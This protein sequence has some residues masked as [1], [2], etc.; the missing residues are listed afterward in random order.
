MTTQITHNITQHDDYKNSTRTCVCGASFTWE[1][2][3]D[4]LK[5][6]MEKHVACV[7]Q[8]HAN[9]SMALRWNESPVC[10]W[11]GFADG[12]A[13]MEIEGQSDTLTCQKCEKDY[14]V[15]VEYE[16]HYTTRVS[17]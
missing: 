8:K 6:W 11:C 10:P 13:Y 5:P 3:S 4:D 7:K 9:G 1:G 2:F 16:P 17:S 14:V 12:D 15:S